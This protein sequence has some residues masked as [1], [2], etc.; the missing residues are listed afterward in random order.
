MKKMK[1]LMALLLA[2][3]MISSLTVCGSAEEDP[4]TLVIYGPGVFGDVPEEGALSAYT[5]EMTMG[6]GKIV[7]RW[8][9]LHPNVTLD[10]QGIG[11]SDWL[12]AVQA[13]VLGGDVDIIGHGASAV[14]LCEPLDTYL[15][16]DPEFVEQLYSLPKVYTEEMEGSVLNIPTVVAIPNKEGPAVMVINTKIFADYGIDLPDKDYTWGDVVTLASKLTGTDPVTG[17]QTY[18]FMMRGLGN[19]NLVKTYRMIAS[20]YGAEI[21]A[22]GE[23]AADSTVDFTSDATARVFQTMMDL[24]E[25]CSPDNV[26]G[27]SDSRTYASDNAAMAWSEDPVKELLSIKESGLEDQ[28]IILP[29]PVI[30]EGE[31]AGKPSMFLG[32]NN[33]GISRTSKHKE[34]AWE[35]IKFLMTDEIAVEFAVSNGMIWNTEEGIKALDAVI[36]SENA[37]IIKYIMDSLPANYNDATSVYYDSVNFGS[38]QSYLSDTLWEMLKKDMTI[39]EAQAKV[40]QSVDDYLATLQ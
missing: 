5:G 7:E 4:I 14:A 30:E 19:S 2:A 39:E 36:G 34:W 12:A 33:L 38:M 21:V 18:G 6:W 28:Y 13:A 35:F 40:Q 27:V 9:E 24:V 20:A 29:V 15:E 31:N 32:N 25:Y 3:M 10:I 22:Y 11:W 1:K 16:E 8:N 26:N 37:E 17:E 23:T